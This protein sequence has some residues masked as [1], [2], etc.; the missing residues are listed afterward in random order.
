M[1]DE[2]RQRTVNQTP[3]GRPGRPEDVA[4]AVRYLASEGASFVTGEVLH[5]NGGW[6]FGR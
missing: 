6:I 4:E 3:M 1:T 5:V 2:R